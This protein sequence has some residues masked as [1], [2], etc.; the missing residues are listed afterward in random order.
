MCTFVT[1]KGTVQD[2]NKFVVGG[3][4]HIIL[5]FYHFVFLLQYENS[6]FSLHFDIMLY[7]Y[8]A[9]KISMFNSKTKNHSLYF[10]QE[11]GRVLVRLAD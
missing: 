10:A 2:K 3:Q 4:E 7:W 6:V 11:Y 5:I 9:Q 8:L 1:R